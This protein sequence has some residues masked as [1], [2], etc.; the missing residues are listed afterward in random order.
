MRLTY[1]NLLDAHYRYIGKANNFNDTVLLTDFQY[2]LGQRYQ[3]IFGSLSGYVNQDSL[4]ASTVA[5]Q[6]YY[7]YPPGTVGVDSATITIGSVQYTLQ[8]IYDQGLWNWWNALQI[9]PTAI[10]QFIFPRKSDFGIWPIPQA[11]YTI[12]FQRFFRDRNLLVADYSTGTATMT[13]GSATVT[14][15]TT[16]FTDAMVGRWFTVTDLTC[17]GQGY[18]YRVASVTSATVLT[19]ETDWASSTTASPV[20]YRIGETPEIP[21]EAHVILPWGTAADYYAGL[22]ADATKAAYYNNLFWTGD[23][24]NS[25]RDFDSKNVAGG[26]IGMIKK[27]ADRER[28]NIV[29]RQPQA[30]S[31]AYKVFA[32]GIL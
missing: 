23:S 8:P 25:A 26:L 19:L 30:I 29:R 24:Q 6:Q 28:D 22:R 7:Y 15:T 1:T 2:S 17:P 31:P 18:W 27:Y 5:S 14:G 9:Q 11:V 3:M 13:A 10:P 16:T 21:E 4:T 20:T 12:N 32:E